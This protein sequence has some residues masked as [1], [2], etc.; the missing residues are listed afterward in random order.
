[1]VSVTLVGDNEQMLIMDF[2][3]FQFTLQLLSI[4][5]LIQLKER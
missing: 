4:N 3:A 1:M 2:V 5:N